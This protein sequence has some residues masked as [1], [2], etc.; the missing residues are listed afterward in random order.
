MRFYD[1]FCNLYCRVTEVFAFVASRSRDWIS[2]DF[3][4][5]GLCLWDRSSVVALQ[6]GAVVWVRSVVVTGLKR[7]VC[8]MVMSLKGQCPFWPCCQHVRICHFVFRLFVLIKCFLFRVSTYF[9]ARRFLWLVDFLWVSINLCWPPGSW[10][11]PRSGHAAYLFP[12]NLWPDSFEYSQ[13][14]ALQFAHYI[15]TVG[16]IVPLIST[17][18][19]GRIAITTCPNLC[20]L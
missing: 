2:C 7:F 4:V 18:S 17:T 5:S 15:S 16:I 8:L 20:Q 14:L 1:P 10:C 19:A 3:L 12:V 6:P 13:W 11:S 9:I